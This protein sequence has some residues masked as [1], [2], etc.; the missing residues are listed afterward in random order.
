M[1]PTRITHGSDC[2]DTPA[3]QRADAIA[4]A[5][6][7][8]GTLDASRLAET[9]SWERSDVQA[10]VG[11]AA[12]SQALETLTPPVSIHIDQIVAHGKAA[13]VSGRLTRDG[14]GT[15][16]F[17]HII[18]FTNAKALEI[19]QLVSFELIERRPRR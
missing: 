7:G 15:M 11:R 5:L 6:M 16:L 10:T 19:A 13:T 17:C 1:T 3:A 18:R 14:S 4:R 2:E 9:A 12:I 8:I